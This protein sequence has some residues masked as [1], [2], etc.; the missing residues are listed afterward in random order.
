MALELTK[1]FI[2]ENKLTDEQVK[3]IT[4]HVNTWHDTQVVELKGEYDT[5]AHDNAQAILDGAAT[6][7]TKITKIDRKEGEKVADF[8]ARSWTDFSKAG[9]AELDTKKAE[10][11]AKIK[12]FK[13]DDATKEQL[14]DTLN[15]LDAIQKKTADYDEL[16]E[17]KG[18]FETLSTEHLSMKER[19]VFGNE[20][21]KFPET[22][23]EYRA[24]A[25][26]DEF[27]DKVKKD[28]DVELVDGES[29]AISK[30][31]K[32]K[33]VK[34][35]DLIASDESISKLMEGRKQTGPGGEEVEKIK[36]DGI[37]FDVPKDLT[38][39]DRAELIRVELAK[40]GLDKMSTAYSTKFAE[41]N[42]KI[43]T[44]QTAQ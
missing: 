14:Q 35:K 16:S 24:K 19:V 41:Y 2:E 6:S 43:R 7:I 25:K 12:D 17:I 26:W 5:K 13:G 22:V 32:H 31:N 20:K 30:E 11:E 38:S 28:Y 23:D 42:D 9:Q 36:I 37:P 40:Q 34:L 1:E 27:V 18:K 39:K 4:P 15:K 8:M 10:Y 44:Q 33:I 21:P 29:M 3:A